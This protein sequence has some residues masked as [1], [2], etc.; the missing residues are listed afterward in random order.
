MTNVGLMK[1]TIDG[2]SVEDDRNRAQSVE[3]EVN[4]THEDKVNRTV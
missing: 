3:D 1:I 2:Q 4:R